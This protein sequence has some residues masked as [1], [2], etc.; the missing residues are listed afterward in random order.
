MINLNLLSSVTLIF[1]IIG[2]IPVSP[3][4]PSGPF[5]PINPLIFICVDAITSLQYNNCT[6]FKSLSKIILKL[7][8]LKLLLFIFSS[9]NNNNSFSLAV[10][11]LFKL[12]NIFSI[13]SLKILPNNLILFSNSSLIFFLNYCL[14]YQNQ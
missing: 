11:L 9:N 10:I 2:V 3:F 7:Y 12:L 4:L 6:L 8:L 14:N 13:F 5:G 1:L